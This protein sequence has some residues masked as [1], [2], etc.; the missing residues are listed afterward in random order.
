MICE[1]KR[2]DLERSISIR[3]ICS[4]SRKKDGHVHS[5]EK[6][7]RNFSNSEVSKIK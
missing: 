6:I 7:I 1:L 2:V 3:T 5:V 4:S